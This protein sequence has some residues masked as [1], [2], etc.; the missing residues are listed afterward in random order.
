MPPSHRTYNFPPLHQHHLQYHQ[1]RYQN[2]TQDQPY[3]VLQLV[4]MVLTV[5]AV[6][7][8]KLV[9]KRRLMTVI[10]GSGGV[11]KQYKILK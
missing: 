4:L 6:A 10:G 7:N 3:L 5:L 8:R 2:H 11:L 9:S 1:N